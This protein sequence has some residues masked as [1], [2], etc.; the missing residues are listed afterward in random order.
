MERAV[1]AGETLLAWMIV[2]DGA[3]LMQATRRFLLAL[4]VSCRSKRYTETE[5]SGLRV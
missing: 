3:P 2:Q 1:V 5:K 4:V